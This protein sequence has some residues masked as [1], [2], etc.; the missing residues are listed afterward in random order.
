MDLI[1]NNGIEDFLMW[2]HHA[3]IKRFTSV[4]DLLSEHGIMDTN[5][6]RSYLS[7]PSFTDELRSIYGIGPKT[8]DYFCT[9][10]GVDQIAVDR[11]VRSFA[12]QA[13]VG[14][15]GYEDLR[16][17][18]C[19]AADLLGVARRDFDAWVWS[20][21]SLNRRSSPQQQLTLTL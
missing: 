7:R 13:G 5:S 19:C 4:V 8:L 1:K 18:F 12:R 2:T 17:V 10:V 9:L 16:L 3:K 21:M 20:T 14:V 11:H 15:A 6:F